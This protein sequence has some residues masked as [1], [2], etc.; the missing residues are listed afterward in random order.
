MWYTYVTCRANPHADEQLYL[1]ASGASVVSSALTAPLGLAAAHSEPSASIYLPASGSDSAPRSRS[2]SRSRAENSG[3]HFTRRLA[4]VRGRMLGKISQ[5]WATRLEDKGDEG[6]RQRYDALVRLYCCWCSLERERAAA[7]PRCGVLCSA[8]AAQ[9][10]DA[11]GA[12]GGRGPRTRRGAGGEWSGASRGSGCCG[13]RCGRC[14][15][16]RGRR[17]D[18]RAGEQHGGSLWDTGGECPDARGR[19]RARAL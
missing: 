5:W 19:M 7:D 6:L 2:R 4:A 16:R 10:R 8:D 17:A 18:E 9:G 1:S 14:W 11:R 12:A 15:S 3:A 13:G